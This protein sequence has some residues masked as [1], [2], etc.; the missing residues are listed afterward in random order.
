MECLKQ[1]I[2]KSFIFCEILVTE[3][4]A[5][6]VHIYSPH[7]RLLQFSTITSTDCSPSV[8]PSVRLSVRPSVRLSVRP[9][10]RPFVLNTSLA[11]PFSDAPAACQLIL[12]LLHTLARS[13]LDYRSLFSHAVFFNMLF[14]LLAI[15][16]LLYW[17]I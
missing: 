15:V 6:T 17:L 12:D 9:S 1:E 14:H 16:C 4:V 5:N 3:R 7:L 13:P 8:R 11:I 2:W 10:V